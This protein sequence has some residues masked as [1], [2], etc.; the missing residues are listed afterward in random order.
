FNRFIIADP[1]RHLLL[2]HLEQDSV[3]HYGHIFYD[4][5]RVQEAI[6]HIDSGSYAHVYR[7]LEPNAM[8]KLNHKNHVIKPVIIKMIPLLAEELSER[9]TNLNPISSYH[10]VHNEWIIQR[11]LSK[12]NSRYQHIDVMEDCGMPITDCLGKLK[13]LSCVSIVKQL[14]IGLMIAETVFQFEHRDLHGGNVL[15][16]TINKTMVNY[17]IRN[18]TLSLPSYGCMVKIIDT[19]FSRIRIGQTV[20]YKQLSYLFT[21]KV[22]KT[23]HMNE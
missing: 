8:I 2:N 10:D 16:Q 23:V 4:N 22:N 20:S 5:H 9:L 11:T 13:P 1:Y 3:L 14:I 21:I 15:V 12:L 19:T 18:R 7:L 17:M 6:K